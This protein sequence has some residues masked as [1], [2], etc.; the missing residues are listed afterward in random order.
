MSVNKILSA[1]SEKEMDRKEFLKYMMFVMAGIA[2]I[3]SLLSLI[4]AVDMNP[5]LSLSKHT[6]KGGGYNGG[7][8]NG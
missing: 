8:Y 4:A 7:R 3:K 6:G 5:D 2:G 1:L